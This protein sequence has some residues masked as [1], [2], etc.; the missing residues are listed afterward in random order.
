MYK[1]YLSTYIF[2]LYVAVTM[3]KMF[4]WLFPVFTFTDNS[5]SKLV[6]DQGYQGALAKE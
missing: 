2:C 4:Y 1:D 3:K 5:L 6:T